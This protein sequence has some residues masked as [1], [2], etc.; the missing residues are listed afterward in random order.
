MAKSKKSL[1]E[2][3]GTLP[4][5]HNIKLKAPLPEGYE[6]K[7]SR[8]EKVA[9]QSFENLKVNRQDGLRFDFAQGWFQIR[10]SNTEPIFRLIIETSDEKLTKLIKKEVMS[11]FK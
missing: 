2:L 6:V 8:M 11:F 9:M 10:K 4:I 7:V 3:V 1:S 5:Y